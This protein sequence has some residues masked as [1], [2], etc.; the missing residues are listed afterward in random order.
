[1][2]NEAYLKVANGVILL[3]CTL[4]FLR[5]SPTVQYIFYGFLTSSVINLI[6]SFLYVTRHFKIQTHSLDR[7]FM[8]KIAKMSIPFFL[9]GIFVYFYSDVNVVLLKY[10]KGTQEV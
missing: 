5:L 7:A 9:G 1:M 10:F 3:L 2:Q 6:I 8:R 4:F